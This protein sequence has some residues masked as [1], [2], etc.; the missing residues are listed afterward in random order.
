MKYGHQLAGRRLPFP[1]LLWGLSLAGF[2]L[3]TAAEPYEG[4]LVQYRQ[5]DG[6]TFDVRLWGDEFFA[7]QETEEGYLVVRDPQSKQFCYARVTADEDNIVSTSVRVGQRP[8]PGLARKQRLA[9]GKAFAK[10]RKLRDLMGV[11]ERGRPKP[12]QGGNL[13]VAPPRPPSFTTTGQRVGLV[14][15][16][17]FPDRPQDVTI[18]RS[19]VDAYCN[20]PDYTGFSNATSV[21][22]YFLKQS[23]GT[24]QYNCIV[25]AYFTAAN[26]RSYYTDPAVSYGT[27]AR[28][29]IREG[30]AVLDAAGFDF[31]EC[32]ADG[33]GVID[34]VNCFYAG[35]RVNAWAEGLWP[36]KSSTSWS[37]FTAHG[38][39]TGFQYQI[40]NIGNALSLGTFC[41][42]NGHMLCGFPDLYSYNGNAARIANYSLMA[43][44]GSKHPVNVD[45]YLKLHAGWADVVDLDSSS[46]QWCAVQVDRNYFYRY[47][48]PAESRE[49]FLIELRDNTGY[50]G[51]Y[52]FGGSVNPTAGVVVYHARENGRN[53]Y[54]SIFTSLNP[55]N[56]YSTPYE[57]MVVE[58]NP[59]ASVTP[60]YDD[61]TPNSNDGLHAGDISEFSDATAPALRFWTAD[62][63]T[64]NSFL[65]VH[66]VSASDSNMT[67][68]V[69]TGTPGGPPVIGL[70]V[71]AL[72]PVA[73]LGTDADSQVFGIYNGAGGTLT[74]TV[75]DDA[76]WLS[77]LPV[78]GTA[79][80]ETD[81]VTVDYNTSG[82][83]SGTH[84]ATITVTDGGAS[85]SPRTI[86]VTLTVHGAPA[87]ALSPSALSK[88]LAP[89]VPGETFLEIS[90]AG[91]GTMDYTISE[92]LDWLSLD[93]TGGTAAAELDRI[94]VAFSDRIPSGTYNGTIQ[95]A[96]TTATNSPQSVNVT[97]TVTGNTKLFVLAPDGG[98]T[99]YTGS[100]THITWNASPSVTG[101]M[102]IELL[103]GG[104]VHTTLVA[105]T[106]NDGSYAWAPPPLLGGTNFRVRITNLDDGGVT[107]ESD[108]SFSIRTLIVD[109][110]LASDPG[111][112]TD[113]PWEYAV[114]GSGNGGSGPTAAY[115][116]THIYDTNPDGAVWSTCYLT[117]PAIDCATYRDTSLSFAGQFSVY[118]GFAATVQISTDGASWS[119]L[120][121][122]Q[123]SHYESSWQLHSYDV[124]SFADGESTIYVRWG[125]IRNPG[126]GNWSGMAVDDI[127]LDGIYE[128]PVPTD[129][130]PPSIFSIR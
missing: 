97:F 69:G 116:G 93:S 55:T 76:G 21:Y 20:E 26:N 113:S 122:Q 98:E 10:S 66:S 60:W 103:K 12:L 89:G 110:T 88:T 115:T 18:T 71:S 117:T 57:L 8:P 59:A 107:D 24:L 25:T 19:Q 46:H 63:R 67:F 68:I 85:N 92:S 87:I 39:S 47:R 128:A 50:E 81:L 22:G 90:N 130:P 106:A 41:H 28:E 2:A 44:S 61:P 73:D 17:S 112:S 6:T 104:S 127:V 83:G 119:N 80:G 49:Y 95:V 51:P 120:Y 96:S 86:P 33:N 30:L 23:N 74:Y 9:P 123:G 77:V 52:A 94:A 65:H 45:A 42:E 37:G 11:D 1:A 5:P 105:S 16:A 101:N 109:D 7:Y 118:T 72:T 79:T 70:T 29:L 15:L 62:G 84:N 54:S 108:A 125:H 64:S 56:V 14:L 38:L 111:Y 40:T 43:S 27:R 75:N 129:F 126:G 13:P 48:N 36:H 114:P 91:G 35:S 102:E 31:T 99:L 82:L 78:S 34:G 4:K 3:Q 53:T 58:A 32:D 121:Y 124:S 100:A